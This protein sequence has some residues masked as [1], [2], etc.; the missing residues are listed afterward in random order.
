ME[1][2]LQLEWKWGC[3][4]ALTSLEYLENFSEKQFLEFL[5]YLE[6]LGLIGRKKSEAEGS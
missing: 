2:L 1:V 4:G 5:K 3:A 6:E